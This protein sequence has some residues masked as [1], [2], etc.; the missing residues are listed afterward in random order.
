MTTPSRQVRRY[1]ARLAA[2]KAKSAATHERLKLPPLRV[3]YDPLPI[4]R[5]ARSK[6]FP[7][8]GAKERARHA[9]V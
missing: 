7:H 6:Y 2:K 3:Q 1:H 4:V 8:L 5:V 9:N